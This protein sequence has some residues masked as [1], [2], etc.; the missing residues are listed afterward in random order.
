MNGYGSFLKNNAPL[1]FDPN[2]FYSSSSPTQSQQNNSI[3]VIQQQNQHQSAPINDFY[4]A[5]NQPKIDSYNPQIGYQPSSMP[6]LPAQ[7]DMNHTNYAPNQST[8]YRNMNMIPPPP[9]S[10]S[11]VDYTSGIPLPPSQTDNYSSWNWNSIET[12][13]SPPNFE[14]KGRDD[15]MVEYIDESLRNI[16]DANDIDHRRMIRTSESDGSGHDVDHRNLISLTGSPANNNGDDSVS[17]QY[18]KS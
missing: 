18:Y 11:H 14:R 1:P 2:E 12:P 6:P 4:N 17:R 15:N 16:T 8:S 3:Q 10:S 7:V 13:H 9:P 5:L